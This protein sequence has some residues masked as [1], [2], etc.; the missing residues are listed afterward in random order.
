[1]RPGAKIDSFAAEGVD[2][3]VFLGA[4]GQFAALLIV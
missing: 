4:Q 3:I 2:N 1:V